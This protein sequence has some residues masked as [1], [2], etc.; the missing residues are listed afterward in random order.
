MHTNVAWYSG[1]NNAII[2]ESEL[3]LLKSFGMKGID[4]SLFCSALK[5]E[6]ESE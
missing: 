3:I 2:F 6:L 1:E 5:T 4:V